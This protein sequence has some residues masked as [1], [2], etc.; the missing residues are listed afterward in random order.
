MDYEKIYYTCQKPDWYH[1]IDGYKANNYRNEFVRDTAHDVKSDNKDI[2]KKWIAMRRIANYIADQEV[3]GPSDT[4]VPAPQHTGKA[5]YTLTIAK[6]ISEKTGC[7][8]NDCL[9]CTPREELYNLKKKTGA[10][11]VTDTGMFL[12]GKPPKGANIWFLD[13]IVAS[14]ATFKDAK[15]LIPGI[16]PLPYAVVPHAKISNDKG[17]YKVTYTDKSGEKTTR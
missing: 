7:E 8:I 3:L 16:K 5:D 6:M 14:G 13:N 11:S 9:G 2:L 10:N 15:T 4:I 1:D 17:E 12:T